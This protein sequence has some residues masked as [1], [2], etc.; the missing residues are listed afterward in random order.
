MPHLDDLNRDIYYDVDMRIML[1]TFANLSVAAYI[2]VV[3][4]SGSFIATASSVKEVALSEKYLLGNQY[5]LPRNPWKV[6]A[7]IASVQDSDAPAT[8][9]PIHGIGPLSC[10]STSADKA[11]SFPGIGGE[12]LL[13]DVDKQLEAPVPWIGLY[14]AGASLLCSLGMAVDAVRGIRSKKFWIPSSYFSLNSVSLTLLA[15]AMKLPV[16]LTTRMYTVT[17]RLAKIG[18]LVFMSTSMA[19]FLTSLGSMTDRDILMNVAALGILV[20]TVTVNVVIQVFQ[21]R[22]FLR[23]RLAFAE[24]IFSVSAMLL[25]LVMFASSALMIPSM[26]WYLETKYREMHTSALDEEGVST[27]RISTNELRVAIKKY[28]L[29]AKT[30]SPQFVIAR[31]VTCAASGAVSL[32]VALAFVLL[33]L[34]MAM[35]YKIF[36]LYD[37]SYGWSTKWI[38][39]SQTVGVVVGTVAPASRWF[40]AVKFRFKNDEIK[41]GFVVES[42][43]TQKMFDWKQRSLSVNIR[44]LKFR[45][46]VHNLRGLVLRFTIFAQFLLVITSKVLLAISICLSSPAILTL[47]YIR[48]SKLRKCVFDTAKID[49]DHY[50]ILL[51][52]ESKLPAETLE[53]ICKEMD[54]VI[55]EGKSKK[56]KNLLKLLY[57]SSSFGGV[58]RFDNPEV[59][60]LHSQELPYCW[61]LP[62][63]TLTSIALA[64]P[65]VE[66][67]KSRSLLDSVTEGISFLK[68]VDKALDRKGNLLNIRTA[69]DVAWVGVELFHKWQDNDL[70]ET[71]LKGKEAVEIL[72]ELCNNAELTVRDFVREARDCLM[73]NPLNWPARVIA[74]NSMY[75]ISSAILLGGSDETGER[76][77]EQL[78]VTVADI[79]GACLTNMAHVI[80]N[81]CRRNAIEERERSVRRAAFLL[82]ET[83]DVI[84]LVQQLELP[85]LALDRMA[86]IEEWRALMKKE[87]LNDRNFNYYE[88]EHRDM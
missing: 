28:W 10:F 57:R 22:S 63:I 83:E 26:K 41:N 80:T 27:G 58:M 77:F 17:D 64:L 62:V 44:H 15:V 36:N 34:R 14:I 13:S 18:S 1:L 67:K 75:R 40:V 29:M 85:F 5:F 70:H 82:G 86:T 84:A 12:S 50:V 79:M 49:V 35:K 55:S 4:S 51:E 66:K 69:A 71:S 60:N 38:L 7:A 88:G 19:N 45:K 54:D 47:S 39:L 74:A 16:D 42:Y 72:R 9:I 2:R 8:Y 33:E 31:S 53:N 6:S 37:S 65:N 43:W 87:S 3:R 61:A 32:F 56:P 81:K 20:V 30:S 76:L 59:S 21:L 24:E 23:G 11:V 48:R 78:S 46:V 52:G 25:L 68:I 73:R